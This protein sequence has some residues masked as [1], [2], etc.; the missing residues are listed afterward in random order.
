MLQIALQLIKY[1]VIKI[2]DNYVILQ[3]QITKLGVI[4]IIQIKM[5]VQHM[6]GKTVI[7]L[8]QDG[9]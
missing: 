9:T 1:H 3:V 6:M 4:S 8:C 5:C 7:S 2:M